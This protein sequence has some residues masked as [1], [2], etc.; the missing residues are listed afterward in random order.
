MAIPDHENITYEQLVKFIAPKAAGLLVQGLRDRLFV[1]PLV[2]RLSPHI[3]PK[4]I[5]RAPKI[6]TEDKKIRFNSP[7]VAWQAPARERALGRLWASFLVAPGKEQRFIFE[8]IER[9]S[10]PDLLLN[11]RKAAEEASADTTLSKMFAQA[12]IPTKGDP[13]D[14][15]LRAKGVHFAV[16]AK[17]LA[18]DPLQERNLTP[19]FYIADNDGDKTSVIF[20]VKHGAIRVRRITV[21]GQEVM[22]AK[23][24]MQRFRPTW[25]W[26]LHLEEHPDDPTKSTWRVEPAGPDDK[27][28]WLEHKAR[29]AYESSDEHIFAAAGF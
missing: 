25:I 24:A 17:P 16:P 10:R 14:I 2:T 19:V 6:T 15:R 29:V 5:I 8:G 23:R 21:E 18:V 11:V 26:R 13:I 27:K 4:T 28:N 20:A 1:P 12:R 7:E 3:L 22:N 9:V